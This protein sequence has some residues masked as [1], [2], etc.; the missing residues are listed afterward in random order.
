[1]SD[2]PDNLSAEDEKKLRQ[3]EQ[4]GN[5]IEAAEHKLDGPE[6]SIIAQTNRDSGIAWRVMVDIIAGPAVGL[7]IGYALDKVTGLSPLFILV[8]FFLGMGGGFLNAYRTATRKSA[9]IGFK[10]PK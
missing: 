7:L 8:C 9:A 6:S 1:M 10:K 5:R 2:A 4:F 3:L